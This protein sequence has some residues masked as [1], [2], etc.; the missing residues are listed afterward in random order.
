MKTR[1]IIA[2]LL[3]VGILLNACSNNAEHKTYSLKHLSTPVNTSL[4]GLCA[5]DE[6][7]VWLSGSNGTYMRTTDGGITWK[8]GSIIDS[9]DFRD[10]HAFDKDRAI[11]ISA[12]TPALIYKTTDGGIN[13]SL[14]YKNEDKRI[15]FDA[16]DFWDQSNGIAFSD[17]I[18]GRFFIITTIDGGETWSQLMSAPEASENEG[19]FAASGTNMVTFGENEIWLGTTTGRILH[20][21]DRGISWSEEMSP[22]ENIENSAAG[23]FSLAFSEDGNGIMVGGDFL[24]PDDRTKNAAVL[25]NNQWVLISDSQPLGYRSGV[26]FIG[27]SSI[28]IATGPTGTDISFDNGNHWALLDSIGYHAVSFNKTNTSGWLSG[29]EGRVAKVVIQ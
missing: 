20:S 11:M 10:I 3:V 7:T 25:V 23:I 2:R 26:A 13:W 14:K 28:L 12:G 27:G 19:G 6:Q 24:K 16:F 1:F 4:R 22:L 18:D 8:N 15:F 21:F 5:L 9:I 29:S 17:A